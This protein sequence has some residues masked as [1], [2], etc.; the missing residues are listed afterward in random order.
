[1]QKHTRATYASI[2]AQKL[3]AASAARAFALYAE[4]YRMDFDLEPPRFEEV[5]DATE[6]RPRR[7]SR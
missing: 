2:R 1:M 7:L 4:R 5:L 6:H 3:A